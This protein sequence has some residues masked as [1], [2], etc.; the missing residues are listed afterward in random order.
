MK[1]GWKDLLALILAAYSLILPP[2]LAVLGLLA[3]ALFLLRAL[4]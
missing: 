3:L 4:V 1:P 2:V